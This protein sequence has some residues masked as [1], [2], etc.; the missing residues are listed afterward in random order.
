VI[1]IKNTFT[2][3]RSALVVLLITFFITL[4]IDFFFGKLILNKLDPYLSKTNFY[5]RLIRIDHKF[6]H[7][8]FKANV[9]YYKATSFFNKYYTLCT[10][11]HGFK[12]KCGVKRNK[13][14]DIGFIGDSFTEG[15]ALDYENTFVGLFEKNKNLSVANL[16]V[17][18]YAPN[19]YLSKMKY[20]L[21][22]DYKFKHL[23][24]FIDISDLY[25]DNT[26]YKLNKD[27]SVSEKNAKQKNLKRRKFLRHN[28]PL[29][30]YYMYVIKMNIRLNKDVPPLNSK[31]PIFNKK[32]ALKGK[33][34]YQDNDKI[35][36]YDESISK[37][38]SEMIESMSQLYILLKKNDIKLSLAVYPWPQQLQNNDFNSKHVEMWNDF[39]QTK[40]ENFINFFPFFSNEVKKNSFIEVYRKYYFWNDI[41]FNAEGNKVIAN[42]LI[43]DLF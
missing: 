4:F 22:N 14:F 37:T 36:G 42:K 30:N 40:C 25:D 39:C 28:F 13:N 11:N 18:S 9:K 34:T 27:I 19:I 2:L 26:F 33:W 41:H 8:T 38:Q 12:Y 32:A 10:D 31:K 17:T 20:L 23:V 7:H 21:D 3:L 16:G 43:K 5:G 35:E 29:T 24:V 15:V 6:Y 1:L